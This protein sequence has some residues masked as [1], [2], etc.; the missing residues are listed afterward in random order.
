[1]TDTQTRVSALAGHMNSGRHGYADDDRG[2]LTAKEISGLTMVEIAA[3][4]GD[5]A[6]IVKAIQDK[7]GLAL[8]ANAHETT[9]IGETTA[10][11]LGPNRW[12]ILSNEDCRAQIANAIGTDAAVIDQSHSRSVVEIS[13]ASVSA[14]L[15]KGCSLDFHQ[16]AFPVGT[17][18]ATHF[19]HLSILIQRLDKT[20]FRLYLPRSFAASGWEW[21]MDAASEYSLTVE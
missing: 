7:L 3:W 17:C 1:M 5:G 11:W 20:V 2:P 16:S 8:P 6:A 4:D 10:L 12:L 15:S 21:L 9:S 19:A 18:K 13:G 14:L